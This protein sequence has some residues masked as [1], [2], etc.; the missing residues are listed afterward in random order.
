MGMT[1]VEGS[2]YSNSILQKG[3]VETIVYD[4]PILNR[5]KFKDIVGN[6]LTY[7]RETS[8]DG[9]EFYGVNAAWNMKEQGITPYTATLKILGSA[10]ELDD[11]LRKTRSNIN[12]LKAE[13]MIGKAK[14]VQV[15]FGQRFIYGSATTDPLEFDGLHVLIASST[16]NTILAD[17]GDTQTVALSCSTHLDRLLDMIKGRKADGLLMSKGMRRGLTKYLRSV[18]AGATAMKDEFG[19]LIETYNGLPIWA[20]DHVLDTELTSSGAFSAST[21]GLTTSIFALSFAEKGV[22]GIQA[23]PLEVV[24]WA[25]IPGTNKEWCQIRWYPGVMMQSLVASAK[26]VGIDADGTVAA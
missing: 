5:I 23:G 18:G 16:Y 10:G 12:D 26:I 6:A 11:F 2:K 20:S 7:N 9:A 22:E 24:P 19:S 21:G 13:I 17:S 3:V 4:D 8:V 15:K 25:P 1:L 14:A